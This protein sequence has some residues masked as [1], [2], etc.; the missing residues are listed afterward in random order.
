MPSTER[1]PE[2][3]AEARADLEAAAAAVR[4]IGEDRLESLAEAHED[5][6]GLLDAY[7]DRATGSGDFQAFV[8]FE[9]RLADFVEGLPEDLPERET[10]EAIDEDLQKRRLTVSDFEAARSRFDSVEELLDRL[11]TRRAAAER[12]RHLEGEVRSAI[13]ETTSRIDRLETVQSLAGADLDA[14]VEELRDPIERYNDAVATALDRA[15]ADWPARKLFAVLREA[16]R[17]PL[18]PLSAPPEELYQYLETASVGEESVPTLLE[19]AGYSR[20]KLAHYVNSPSTFSRLVGGNRTYLQGIDPDPLQIDWPPP[21]AR[22]LRWQGRELVSMLSRL[23]AETAIEHLRSVLDIAREDPTRYAE[24][25]RTA[26]AREELTD[27]ERE[28]IASGTLTSD[29]EAARSRLEALQ[30]LL[31]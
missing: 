1:L 4:E 21:A 14:P 28:Q 29:L 15:R 7:E 23:E 31:H 13:R 18:V 11:E 30:S 19:Y 26:R 20:S 8:E 3:V 27:A 22:E 6:V 12:V 17:F 25:R 10:F 2:A 5:L 16:R 9:D 24:L